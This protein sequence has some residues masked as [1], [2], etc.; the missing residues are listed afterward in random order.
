MS[1]NAPFLSAYMGP[2]YSQ[3]KMYRKQIAFDL[4]GINIQFRL[5]NL[6][7]MSPNFSINYIHM[8]PLVLAVCLSG[9]L[10]SQQD[11]NTDC[12]SVLYE[13]KSAQL[14]TASG[15]DQLKGNDRY[16]FDRLADS[17]ANLIGEKENMLPCFVKLSLLVDLV[18][19]N[20]LHFSETVNNPITADSLASER[21][22]AEYRSQAA[23]LNF[24]RWSG[25]LD[26][27]IKMGQSGADRTM[28]EYYWGSY[29]QV[30][31]VEQ[32]DRNS[33][34][35]VVTKS[36]LPNWEPGQ[37]FG[38]LWPREEGRYAGVYA[39]LVQKNW[40]FHRNVRFVDGDIPFLNLTL[41]RSRRSFANLAKEEPTFAIRHIGPDIDYIRLGSFSA[42]DE[43]RS[44]AQAFYK[45][46]KDSL[47]ARNIIVD[48][49]NNGGGAFKTS[50]QFL[51]LIKAL[52]RKRKIYLL[53]NYHTVSNA[54]QFVV[55]L[56][57]LKNI[58]IVGQPTR[59]MLTYGNNYGNSVSLGSYKLYITDM[60]GSPRDLAYEDQGI[61]PDIKLQADSDWIQQVV[62]IIKR[63]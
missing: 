58:S 20:H 9:N 62:D 45:R 56:R 7:H 34:C 51:N 37:I 47:S 35:M 5:S 13:L 11:Q 3:T 8:L 6:A 10:Y 42:R 23:F 16:A 25:S 39:Q 26:S 30:A 22:S 38:W 28:G 31:L 50:K 1:A 53:V 49:R 32:T 2:G 12:R 4:G 40:N 36:A 44:I 63:H 18:K 14:K 17:I 46:S 24:P 48:L 57:N 19:D 33:I 15:K 59:G 41:N 21:W 55:R 52:S 61:K 60:K 29:L 43:N 54:E 27:L